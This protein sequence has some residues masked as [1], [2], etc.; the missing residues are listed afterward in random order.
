[1]GLSGT[2]A[3][4]VLG[5]AAT[6][7]PIHAIQEFNTQVNPKAEFGWKPGAI[8]SVGLKSGTNQIHGTAYAF[9]RS[10]KFDARNYFD[11]VGTD[12]TAIELEQ[13]GVTGGGHIIKDKLFYFGAFESQRYSVANSLPGHVPTTAV[14]PA[15]SATPKDNGCLVIKFEDCTTSIPNAIADL[16]AHNPT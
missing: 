10:D 16:S 11:P 7:I 12:K 8:T 4:A 13:F 1:M 15:T 14:V 3:A 6:L 9:G 2:N 5:H